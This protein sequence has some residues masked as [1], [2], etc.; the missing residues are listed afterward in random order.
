[1][2]SD[3]IEPVLL[4]L[5]LLGLSFISSEPEFFNYITAMGFLF[6]IL[7]CKESLGGFFAA[8]IA[9]RNLNTF[10]KFTVAAVL[11]LFFGVA[12]GFVS[13][14]TFE[15]EIPKEETQ[16]EPPNDEEPDVYPD[17][18][19]FFVGGSISPSDDRSFSVSL[20]SPQDDLIRPSPPLPIDLI[21]GLSIPNLIL[22]NKPEADDFSYNVV[23]PSKQLVPIQ[24]I[25]YAVTVKALF[26]EKPKSW[27]SFFTYDS[28]PF[29]FTTGE[30]TQELNALKFKI[31]VE[32]VKGGITRTPLENLT[33]FFGKE[34]SYF[35]VFWDKLFPPSENFTYFKNVCKNNK[36]VADQPSSKEPCC[37]PNAFNCTN[38]KMS[39]DPYENLDGKQL[40]K[41]VE[42]ATRETTDRV[43][44]LSD[45]ER[46]NFAMFL[47]ANNYKGSF[48]IEETKV[49]T[50]A[51]RFI[52]TYKSFFGD[53]TSSTSTFS[54]PSQPK[55]ALVIR[56]VKT[57]KFNKENKEEREKTF[58]F[59]LYPKGKT[60]ALE[61]FIFDVAT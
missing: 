51:Q 1:M 39:G 37:Q 27:A 2:A 13:P 17:S 58:R 50:A 16:N 53:M 56:P 4:P 15:D 55:D 35:R 46:A 45:V 10:V 40:P 44:N 23:D 43:M 9:D 36:C 61:A 22:P 14:Q 25:K 54:Q 8:G 47:Y 52:D 38:C 29:F 48:F 33:F 59:F 18:D 24:V 20:I 11:L 19:Y 26:T 32:S 60:V 12:F 42:N 21:M 30:R 31:F 3:K 41:I 49:T 6:F 7:F 28:I 5:F 57:F 34:R